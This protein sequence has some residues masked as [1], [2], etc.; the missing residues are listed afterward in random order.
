[1]EPHHTNSPTLSL[2]SENNLF[3]PD[4]FENAR[5]QSRNFRSQQHSNFLHHTSRRP[6]LKQQQLQQLQ[7][8]EAKIRS[9]GLHLVTNDAENEIIFLPSHWNASPVNQQQFG[10]TEVRH[11]QDYIGSLIPCWL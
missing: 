7:D 4:P 3:L 9:L 2:R 10:N 8:D 11:D 1:M 5:A 6:P